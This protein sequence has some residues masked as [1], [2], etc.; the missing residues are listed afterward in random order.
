MQVANATRHIGKIRP[1]YNGPNGKRRIAVC[2]KDY[3]IASATYEFAL[4]PVSEL[5][6]YDY[7]KERAF[8]YEFKDAKRLAKFAI[9]AVNNCQNVWKTGGPVQASPM[10]DYNSVIQKIDVIISQVL[11]DFA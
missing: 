5:K 8:N 11:E 2:E 3:R 9:N 10:T 6:P 7:F 4:K 1:R